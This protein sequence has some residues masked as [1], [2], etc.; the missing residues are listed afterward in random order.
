VQGVYVEKKIEGKKEEEKGQRW[1]FS[2]KF[3]PFYAILG[4]CQFTSIFPE[5]AD[6]F[7]GVTSS[8]FGQA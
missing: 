5:Y 3:S 4:F 8:G 2:F 7:W 6:F 1:T